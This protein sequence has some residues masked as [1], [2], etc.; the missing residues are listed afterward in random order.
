M[1]G[2]CVRFPFFVL[3]KRGQVSVVF[4]LNLFE[5]HLFFFPLFLQAEVKRPVPL[6]P[7]GAPSPLDKDEALWVTGQSNED[8]LSVLRILFFPYVMVFPLSS[9]FTFPDGCS[10]TP[11]YMDC[12]S[13]LYPLS[14][15][16]FPFGRRIL[17]LRQKGLPP[18]VSQGLPSDA[19][20]IWW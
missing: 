13:S 18:C 4:F 14:V 1:Y 15:E 6:P 17:V 7:T 2:F 12:T 3:E 5:F 10:F 20:G 9:F 16:R 8:S 19:D 11:P